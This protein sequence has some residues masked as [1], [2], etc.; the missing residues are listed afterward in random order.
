MVKTRTGFTLIEL[1]VVIAIIA[2]LTA[3]LFPV[4]AK[5]RDKARQA[6]CTSNLKQ[7]GLSYAMYTQDWDEKYPP[8]YYGTYLPGTQWPLQLVSYIKNDSV[9]KCPS[10]SRTPAAWRPNAKICSY[11]FNQY[12]FAEYYGSAAID[13]P[14]SVLLLFEDKD[15]GWYYIDLNTYTRKWDKREVDNRHSDGGNILFADSHVKWYRT[16]ALPVYDESNPL[17]TWQDVRFIP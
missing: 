1:L 15:P 12:L 5:A 16:S 3:I 4:F 10:D 8:I 11:A 7:L 14:A 13:Q 9:W 6:S 17:Y 2:I